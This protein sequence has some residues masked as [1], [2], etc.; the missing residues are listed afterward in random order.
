METIIINPFLGAFMTQNPFDFM[1]SFKN[2]MQGKEDMLA[3][4]RKN[5]E[6]LSEANRMAVDVIKNIAQLQQQYIKQTFETISGMMGE[7]MANPQSQETWKKSAET[8]QDQFNRSVQHGVNVTQ[9]L[10][11]SHKDIYDSMRNS[12]SQQMEN[13][14]KAGQK[15]KH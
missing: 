1:A 2:M 14:K 6:A 5:I 10:S 13:V 8:V 9:V 3:S 15:A 7:M 12:L 11:K 4:Q